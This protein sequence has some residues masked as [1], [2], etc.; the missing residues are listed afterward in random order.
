MDL[1]CTGRKDGQKDSTRTREKK[2]RETEPSC[3]ALLA[4]R[5]TV[6]NG[7]LLRRVREDKRAAS[8][9]QTTQTEYGLKLEQLIQQSF[10]H[11]YKGGGQNNRNT[12]KRLRGLNPH[13]PPG[14]KDVLE[15][16]Q[17]LSWSHYTLRFT[18]DLKTAESHSTC[19]K[20]GVTTSPELIF[21]AEPEPSKKKLL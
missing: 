4:G 1:G 21:K 13:V 8:P 11:W 7:W 2:E 16:G 12:P 15:P 19:S 18:I 20:S 17:C 5:H 3:R 6:S 10:P 14:L 9:L